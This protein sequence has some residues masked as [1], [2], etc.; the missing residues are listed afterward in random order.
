MS[1]IKGM[2]Q[3]SNEWHDLRRT[4][5]TGT[6]S[7]IILKLNPWK[8]PYTLFRQKMGLE[9]IEITS[10]ME[11]GSLLEAEAR[12]QFALKMFLVEP[13]VW[14]SDEHPF[15]M[16]S[17]DG[18]GIENGKLSAVEI[19]CGAKSYREAQKGIV[20]PYYKAQ[21][22]H[23]LATLGLD[24]IYY[25]AY[26][27]GHGIL[28]PIYRDQQFIDK[29]IEKEREFYSHLQNM[30]YPI[31]E[32]EDIWAMP[33]SE[34]NKRLETTWKEVLNEKNNGHIGSNY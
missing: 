27:D 9:E 30:S 17:L 32:S 2:V 34:W 1:E 14:V 8:S 25:W 33:E 11:E 15:M 3:G 24:M 28:I 29:M 12:G 23:Q 5:I 31:E 21:C 6:D 19:K 7:S 13:K 18:V 20:P 22:Q 10:A 26:R 16:A 4:K